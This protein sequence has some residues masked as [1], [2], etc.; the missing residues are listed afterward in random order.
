MALHF[1]HPTMNPYRTQPA[2]NVSWSSKSPETTM[3]PSV[4]YVLALAAQLLDLMSTCSADRIL[5]K[6]SGQVLSSQLT[7]VSSTHWHSGQACQGSTSTLAAG[8]A[9]V[10]AGS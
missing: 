7:V 6:G 3:G 2:R 5:S 8:T 9:A 10:A 1:L 4:A